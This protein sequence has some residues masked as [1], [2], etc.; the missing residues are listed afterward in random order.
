MD[1]DAEIDF[2]AFTEKDVAAL[3]ICFAPGAQYRKLLENTLQ[4]I[5]RNPEIVN[6][7]KSG[8]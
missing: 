2:L 1:L 5:W 8:F 6:S 3:R 7:T 4:N